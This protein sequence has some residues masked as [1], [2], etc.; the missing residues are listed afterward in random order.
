MDVDKLT[1]RD[2][3]ASVLVQS[4]AGRDILREVVATLAEAELP[5]KVDQILTDI[6]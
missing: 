3:L 1:Y 6:I 5:A 2:E 4:S